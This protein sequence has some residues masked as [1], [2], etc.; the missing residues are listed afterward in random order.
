MEAATLTLIAKVL[1]IETS[2]Y[3]NCFWA[4]GKKNKKTNDRTL[5]SKRNKV[6]I[7]LFL[8]LWK[9]LERHVSKEIRSSSSSVYVGQLWNNPP[10]T[11]SAAKWGIPYLHIFE[12]GTCC[13]LSI[14]RFCTE[15]T[16]M[17]FNSN[18]TKVVSR[19]SIRRSIWDSGIMFGNIKGT[20]N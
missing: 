20:L 6:T 19:P 2:S 1:M 14:T 13:L 4:R 17:I 12:K 5:K 8:S 9:L 10:T 16:K 18:R 3:K 15:K 7:C 11:S